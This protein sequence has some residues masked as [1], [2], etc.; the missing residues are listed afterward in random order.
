MGVASR[1]QGSTRR[2][3][4][5]TNQGCSQSKKYNI[6]SVATKEFLQAPGT[7]N[8]PL[9]L[10]KTAGI[11]T[12]DLPPDPNK[13][14]ESTIYSEQGEAYA[15]VNE[16]KQGE[17]IMALARHYDFAIAPT[18]AGFYFINPLYSELYWVSNATI[19]PDIKLIPKSDIMGNDGL[20]DITPVA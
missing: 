14:V 7:P 1:V 3:P 16:V 12:I 18:A 19:S 11:W 15:G 6:I 5:D 8:G 2:Q 20:F 10:G 13:A 4:G 9:T 17:E